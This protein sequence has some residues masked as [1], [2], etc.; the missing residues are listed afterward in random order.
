MADELRSYTVMRQETTANCQL[1]VLGGN[2]T[3]STLNLS[4]LSVREA[5][6][7][8]QSTKS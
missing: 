5:A 2:A 4:E 6:D 7:I 8:K 3:D 1:D